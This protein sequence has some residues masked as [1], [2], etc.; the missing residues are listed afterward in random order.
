MGQTGNGKSTIVNSIMGRDIAPTGKGQRVTT[1]NEVYL[2]NYVLDDVEYTLNLFDTVGIEL[3][4]KVTSET[5][6][7]I[8][9]HIRT[10]QKEAAISDVNVVWFCINNLNK[11]F[12]DFEIDLIKKL[13]YEYEIPFII[14]MTQ[15]L[16]NQIGELER[17]I[18]S[19]LPEVMTTRILAKDYHLRGGTVIPAYGIDDLL[20]VSLHKNN[21]MK[22]K[23]LETK[24][25]DI[26]KKCDVSEWYIKS[27]REKADTCIKKYTDK[28]QKIGKI[29]ALCIPFVHS[30]SIELIAELHKMYGL[31]SNTD[32]VINKIAFWITGLIAVPL[33]AV[34]VLS[35]TAAR[36]YVEAVGET[37]ANT[38][39][40][41]LRKSKYS[42]LNDQKLIM[43]RIKQQVEQRKGG[44]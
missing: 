41:V 12:Q 13:S 7:N 31:P 23:V 2:A 18:R 5:L 42:E 44:A 16:D 9:E 21:E 4:E 30:I 3:S 8:E 25:N 14:V 17:S 28:A 15:C 10:S 34:P 22:V 11:R 33:M 38:L 39:S 20:R 29:P 24:L 26:K 35:G 32:M 43:E 36:D 40:D 19:E 27:Y 1:K 6:A 37:Y